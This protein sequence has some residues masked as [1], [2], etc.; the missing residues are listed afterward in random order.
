M[1]GVPVDFHRI[2]I[3]QGCGGLRDVLFDLLGKPVEVFSF[4][5]PL[6]EPRTNLVP[7]SWADEVRRL[8][9]AG[10]LKGRLQL[11]AMLYLLAIAGAFLYLAWLK[12]KAQKLDG[13]I[14]NTRPLV[15]F[16][17]SR[18]T[19]WEALAPAV[20][21]S[22]YMVEVLN[23]LNENRPSDEVDFTFFEFKPR[24]FRLDCEAPGA[25]LWT[26]FTDK[27]RK[28]AGL[29][30]FKLRTDPPKIL[31]DGRVQFSVFGTL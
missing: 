29:S 23:L 27:L 4:D 8:Q 2:R 3:E 5:T 9:S 14:A 20:N 30:S 13:Q 15:E 25:H 24:E 17:Q 31:A 19:K 26:E 6:P 10:R 28:E 22:R 12:N 7:S 1:E 11:L 21:P 18:Q 16:Q